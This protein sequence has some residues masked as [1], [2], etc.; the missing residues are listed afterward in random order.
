MITL[1]PYITPY[2]LYPSLFYTSYALT[3]LDKDSRIGKNEKERIKAIQEQAAQ[4][5]STLLNDKNEFRLTGDEE[6]Q[7]QGLYRG[8]YG[9]DQALGLMSLVPFANCSQKSNPQST[10]SESPSAEH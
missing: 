4:K 3:A 7:D 9:A 5:I 8:F 10:S 6:K 1:V 2:Y